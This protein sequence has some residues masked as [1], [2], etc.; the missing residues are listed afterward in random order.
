MGSQREKQEALQN[1]QAEVGRLQLLHL[2][3]RTWSHLKEDLDTILINSF[4]SNISIKKPKRLSFAQT[5]PRCYFVKE[6][7]EHLP[8]PSWSCARARQWDRRLN[9][10]VRLIIYLLS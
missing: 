5:I 8:S 9:I 1:V 2:D 3:E 4:E 10:Y 6:I 7:F